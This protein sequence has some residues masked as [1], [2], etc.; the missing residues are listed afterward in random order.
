LSGQLDGFDIII[1]CTIAYKTH[2]ARNVYN[3]SYVTTFRTHDLSQCGIYKDL[4]RGMYIDRN[5]NGPANRSCG[6]NTFV[7]GRMINKSMGTPN[8]TIID[9]NPIILADKGYKNTTTTTT[10]VNTTNSNR[11]ICKEVNTAETHIVQVSETLYGISKR[12]GVSLA[13][14]RSWNGLQRTDLI[15]PCKRLRIATPYTAPP[16]TRYTPV[17]EVEEVELMTSKG[18]FH[19]VRRGETLYRIARMYGFTTQKLRNMNELGKNTVIRPGQVLK[20]SDCN[21]D[22][23]GN[24]LIAQAYDDTKVERLV[25]KSVEDPNVYTRSRK[26]YRVKIDDTLY[27]LA[28]K[29]NTTVDR[30][31]SLNNLSNE[32]LIQPG[33]ELYL[34]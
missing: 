3:D 21:C 12:Y 31:R 28:K 24:P 29:Y 8:T 30:L 26:V 6:G 23:D 10:V 11:I 34:D 13:Q 33:Q 16:K 17:K 5:T 2:K 14:L 32:N 22:A 9:T 7:N 27:S 15:M 4:D 20:V 1:T 25:A 19:E 18:G